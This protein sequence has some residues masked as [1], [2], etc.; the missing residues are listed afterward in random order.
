MWAE[1]P[2]APPAPVEIVETAAGNATK[3]W[4]LVVEVLH[5]AHVQREQVE[6]IAVGLGPGSY[7]GVRLAIAL[8]QGWQ[9]ARNIRLLGLSSVEAVVAEAAMMGI[10]GR[11]H[12]VVDAQRGEFYLGAFD[13]QPTGWRSECELRLASWNE[14]RELERRGALLV[15]PE[16][17]RWFAAGR[18]VF[19]TARA[20]GPLALSRTDF[21]AGP[22]LTPIYLRQPTFVKAPPGRHIL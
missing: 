17:A 19:P 22:Q 8:A 2:G 1:T 5:R 18:T 20:L 4:N 11:V 3:P 12:V 10:L 14:V 21:L 9:L 16:V 6:C 13:L 15:G 7:T